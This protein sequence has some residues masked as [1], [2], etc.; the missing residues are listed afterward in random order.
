MTEH[1][2]RVNYQTGHIHCYLPNCQLP[3]IRP[4]PRQAAFSD[5]IDFGVPDLYYD[6]LQVADT[7]MKEQGI[8][9]LA[10]KEN[11][12]CWWQ[13]V[14]RH[15]WWGD[16]TAYLIAVLEI[17]IFHNKMIFGEKCDDLKQISKH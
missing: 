10:A 7:N 11:F 4:F 5:G 13:V 2:I 15:L 1:T 16:Q 17:I 6:A 14:H 8:Y 12:I 9:C 3:A